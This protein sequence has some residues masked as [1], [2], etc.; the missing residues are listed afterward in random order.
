VFVELAALSSD[1]EAEPLEPVVGAISRAL[2]VAMGHGVRLIGS[3]L[4]SSTSQFFTGQSVTLNG[5][6]QA[7]AKRSL[8]VP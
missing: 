1:D 8:T 5:S 4:D 2:T 6:K 7:Q 3:S